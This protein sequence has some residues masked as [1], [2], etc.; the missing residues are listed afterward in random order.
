LVTEKT[1][2]FIAFVVV[3]GMLAFVLG[4]LNPKRK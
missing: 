1:F 4:F 3:L 2:Y